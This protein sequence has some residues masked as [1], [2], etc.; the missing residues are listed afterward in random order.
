MLYYQL[1]LHFYL[2][3][4]QCAKTN[5]KTLTLARYILELSLQHYEFV[6]KSQSMM[7]AATLWLAF[8]MNKSDSKW[9]N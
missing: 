4:L 7:A 9:V 3:F 1:I 2:F 5:M 6:G 8:K